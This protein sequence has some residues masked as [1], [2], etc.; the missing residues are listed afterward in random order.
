METPK[1]LFHYTNLDSLA[2]ILESKQIQFSSLDTVND[3][4]EGITKD[5][6]D[7][8]QYIFVSCWTDNSEENLAFWN[9]YTKEMKGVRIKLNFPILET[10]EH[11]Y[12]TPE[13]DSLFDNYF[14]LHT[15]PN[16]AKIEYTN[17]KLKL[18][19]EIRNELGLELRKLGRHKS[20]IWRMESEWR[21]FIFIIPI[22]PEKP[23]DSGHFPDRYVRTLKEKTPLG[24]DRYYFKILEESFKSMEIVCGP[25][26]T[27]G[28]KIIVQSLVDKYNPTA[29]VVDSE[30]KGKIK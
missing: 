4:K 5:F 14:L 20:E 30:I 22:E 29:T 28:E 7:F 13:R 26:M 11:G 21:Y 2:S 18:E 6:G 12:L 25:K 16:I 17:D 3:L 24:F 9:M 1:V 10:F 8:R 19:P 23:N 15:T 27:N